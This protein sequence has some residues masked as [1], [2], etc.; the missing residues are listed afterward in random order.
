[1]VSPLYWVRTHSGKIIKVIVETSEWDGP[2]CKS[3]LWHLQV[4]C[5]QANPFPCIMEVSDS[6]LVKWDSRAYFMEALWD[7]KGEHQSI[8]APGSAWYMRA[9]M[10]LWRLWLLFPWHHVA[11]PAGG[12]GLSF[13]PYRDHE[14]CT[15]FFGQKSTP[16]LSL[17]GK[18]VP[19]D[20][21]LTMWDAF[22][23]CI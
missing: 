19:M 10:H 6:S 11:G 12:V 15:S 22:A 2:R 18:L 4:V 5:L 1:V 9:L 8:L 7:E 3:W 20:F 16:F 21:W 13:C 23:L 17:K 14:P